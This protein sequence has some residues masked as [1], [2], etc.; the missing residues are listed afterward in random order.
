MNREPPNFISRKKRSHAIMRH[1]IGVLTTAAFVAALPHLGRAADAA[2]APASPAVPSWADMLTA[3]GITA[4]GYVAASYYGSNGY[5]FNIHQFDTHHD[6]FQIDEAGFSVAYQPKQGFGALV[7]LI[8]GEDARILHIL[9]DGHDN[10]FDI[11]QAYMQYATGP[12]TVIAGKFVT[13]TGAEVMNPT[14]NTNFSRSL[15]YTES[16]PIDHTGVRATYAASDTLSLILGVNN[17]WNTTSTDFGS[18]TGEAGISWIPNKIFSLSASGYFGR[19]EYLPGTVF[20]VEGDRTVIDVVATYNVTSALTFIVNLDWDQ[21]A[22]AFGVDTH[23][24]TWDGVAGYVNY[25]F[26]S[27][28]RVSF[29]A[30]YLDDKDG[31]ITGASDGQ[32]LWEGTLTFGYAPTAHF[33]LRLEGRYDTAQTNFFYRSDP[34]LTVYPHVPV[35]ADS[36]SEIA[37]QG[38]YKF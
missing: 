38:V 31:F 13:L 20:L 16:E 35:M 4:N 10:T 9:E 2:A 1:A 27:Q 37:L 14:G 15:L 8:A 28:W 36:L 30:E 3:W 34:A 29:R 21:Q 17:G 5:P 33:E 23:T 22:D 24:A 6:T 26:N 32:H 19:E 7:D 18:K 25:A 12:L 11:R